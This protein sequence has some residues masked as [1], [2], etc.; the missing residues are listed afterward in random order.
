MYFPNVGGNWN[1]AANA[2][3]WYV[4]CTDA[5]SYSYSIIGAR[6]ANGYHGQKAAGLRAWVQ[7]LPFGV[8]V[9]T[10]QSGQRST[11]ATG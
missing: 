10:G 3:L 6:L 8:S 5:A 11:A 7:C 4:S 2:G 1:N 9:L